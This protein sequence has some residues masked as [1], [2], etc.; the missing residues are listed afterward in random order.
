MRKSKHSNANEYEKCRSDEKTAD[1]IDAVN[2]CE[3]VTA[4]NLLGGGVLF[5]SFH[6][7]GS[8][9]CSQ[10]VCLFLSSVQLKLSMCSVTLD[11]HSD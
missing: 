11:R 4:P 10:L 7:N 3:C 9:D 1:R 2:C 8:L 5:S 6:S